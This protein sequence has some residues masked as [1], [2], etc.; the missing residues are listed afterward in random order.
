M[1][2]TQTRTV[3]IDGTKYSL[4]ELSDDVKSQLASMRFAE[5]EVQR[6]QRQLALAQTARAAYAR[7]VQAGLPKTTAAA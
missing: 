7:A 3:T 2:E 4:N 5:Q 6:L 1:S